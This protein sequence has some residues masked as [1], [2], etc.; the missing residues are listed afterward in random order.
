MH[1]IGYQPCL[2]QKLFLYPF[3]LLN[4]LFSIRVKVP[5]IIGS[6]LFDPMEQIIY[7]PDHFKI[8][9]GNRTHIKVQGQLWTAS[10]MN[11]IIYLKEVT[12]DVVKYWLVKGGR[13]IGR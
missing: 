1:G 10:L 12:V 6:K 3:P 8:G 9:R 7:F 2:I 4:T 13:I 11:R 5:V